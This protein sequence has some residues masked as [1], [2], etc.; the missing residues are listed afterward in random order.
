LESK[1]K[2]SF[3]QCWTTKDPSFEGEK[4]IKESCLLKMKQFQQNMGQ[5]IK[6]EGFTKSRY[7]STVGWSL[8]GEAHENPLLLKGEV[9][10]QG[11]WHKI[12][13]LKNN[14]QWATLGS[15]VHIA[16]NDMGK[17]KKETAQ[18]QEM[19]RVSHS[20]HN[21]CRMCRENSK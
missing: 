11:I 8:R 12:K 1:K 6:Q 13:C 4:H 16:L 7:K 10:S 20:S 21:H 14:T 2:K 17:V 19:K 3:E 9:I 15:T 5:N 18:G